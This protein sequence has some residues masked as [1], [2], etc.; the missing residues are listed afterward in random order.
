ME[1]LRELLVAAREER[2]E[3]ALDELCGLLYPRVR[4]LVHRSLAS[5]LRGRPW[6]SA[7]FSTSDVVQEVLL[8]VLRDL[9]DLRVEGEGPVAAYL[10]MV[11]RNRLIDAIRFHE[12]AR[13]DHRRVGRDPA[14]LE[15]VG[16]RGEGGG[17]PSDLAVTIEQIRQF[18]DALGA[19]SERDRALLR[20][21][22]EH[23]T[24]FEELSQTLGYASADSARKAFHTAQARLL[25]RLKRGAG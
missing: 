14:L 15:S 12:A 1:R 19:F 6:L 8:G 13:R 2:S 7:L 21:R 22:I 5:E 18:H 24:P 10:A 23:T 9:D 11:T 16:E 20:A 3:Q 17:D 25:A 4:R